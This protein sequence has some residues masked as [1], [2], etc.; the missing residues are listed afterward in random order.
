MIK[1]HG[2]AYALHSRLGLCPNYI[3]FLLQFRSYQKNFFSSLS[4]HLIFSLSSHHQ[5]TACYFQAEI[6]IQ[7]TTPVLSLEV[8]PNAL[9]PTSSVL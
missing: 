3:S 1:R 9:G 4:L 5:E 7:L 8:E 6:C 2:L